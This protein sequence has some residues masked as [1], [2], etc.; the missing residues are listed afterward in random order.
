VGGV[1]GE[2]NLCETEGVTK[3][4]RGLG[5]GRE[6]TG[7]GIGRREDRSQGPASK[8]W[9]KEEKKRGVPSFTSNSTG[10]T[11]YQLGRKKKKTGY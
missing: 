9:R 2:K 1:R 10:L 7:V 3:T 6:L 8:E 4:S 5:Y 11:E